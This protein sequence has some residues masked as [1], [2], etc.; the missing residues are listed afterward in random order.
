MFPK[1]GQVFLFPKPCDVFFHLNLTKIFFSLPKPIKYVCYLC[2]PVIWCIPFLW[3][4]WYIMC[5]S[6]YVTGQKPSQRFRGMQKYSLIFPLSWSD[7]TQLSAPL[8]MTPNVTKETRDAMNCSSQQQL[9]SQNLTWP[10]WERR[11]V[12]HHQRYHQKP[13]ASLD[14][15]FAHRQNSL[16]ILWNSAQYQWR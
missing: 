8:N 15:T 2:C 1:P 3:W 13:H 9:C 7:L 6:V 5:L 10:L 16:V 4:G 11:R 12:M 14:S